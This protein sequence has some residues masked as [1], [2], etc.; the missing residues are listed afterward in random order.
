MQERIDK[1]EKL[2][3]KRVEKDIKSSISITEII[4]SQSFKSTPRGE[5]NSPNKGESEEDLVMR[6]VNFVDELAK[7]AKAVH[8][9]NNFHLEDH[10]YV[11]DE[12]K[13][14]EVTRLSMPENTL[15]PGEQQ[16]PLS[17]EGFKL[18]THNLSK[19]AENYPDNLHLMIATVP[20][21]DNPDNYEGY[22]LLYRHCTYPFL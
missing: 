7:T 1:L 6:M 15:Y 10:L 14:N 2:L 16:G 11:M 3:K 22:F 13:N 9:K 17:L 21:K 20:V 12:Q 18:L 4:V 8:L 19:L 5:F